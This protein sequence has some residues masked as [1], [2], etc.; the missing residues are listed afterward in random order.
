MNLKEKYGRT[1]LVVGASE[2][3]GAA[4]AEHLAAEGMNLVLLAR[5]KDPLD[6]FG[7]K[8]KTK[9]AVEII[10][11]SCDLSDTNTIDLMKKEITDE[12]AILVYNAALPHI[13]AFEDSEPQNN[14]KMLITNMWSPMHLV[15]YFGNEMLKRKKG[16][17]I[18]MSSLAGLQGSGFLSVYAATKAFNRVLAESLW[19]EWKD[20]GVDVIACTAGATA[21][22][23]YINTK[24]R[25]VSI[26]APKVQTPE[27]VVAECMNKLGKQPSFIPGTANKIATFF[28]QRL[29]PAKTA[30][31]IMGD[32][33]RKMYDL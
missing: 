14:T 5:R 17:V 8:L 16:G 24:P 10:T 19:Y 2:G 7:A 33:T 32:T 15:H 27:E 18:L 4:F 6:Q 1:A 12:I 20:K 3:L 22:P 29:L 28:M 9:Y 11:I 30:I 31:K 26:F 13:G 21:T 23:G 25:K